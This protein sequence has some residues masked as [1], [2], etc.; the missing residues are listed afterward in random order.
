LTIFVTEQSI[1][2]WTVNE[3]RTTASATAAQGAAWLI[4]FGITLSIAAVLSFLLPLEVAVLVAV[5]QGGVALP[6]A[7]ALERRLGTAPMAQ[8]HPLRSLS[9]QLAMV[10]IVALPAVIMM[11]TQNPALVPAVFAAIGGAHFLPYVWLH[12]TKIYLYLALGVAL[13]SWAITLAGGEGAYRWVM[14]WWPAC[15][16][17]A[18]A[19]LWRRHRQLHPSGQGNH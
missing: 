3:A 12:Q 19:L 11:Y 9:V 16:I 17:V 13:G 5:F 7:F 15:Y 14:V 10:Q 4:A 1:R 18:A 6:L 8:D 2:E